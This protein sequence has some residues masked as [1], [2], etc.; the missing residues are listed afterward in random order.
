VPNQAARQQSINHEEPTTA[1]DG[2]RGGRCNSCLVE[3]ASVTVP[4]APFPR[5]V[6]PEE[7]CTSKGSQ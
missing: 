6:A 1:A 4:G 2:I 3:S 7:G 5:V